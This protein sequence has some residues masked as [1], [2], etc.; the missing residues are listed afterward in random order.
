VT[1]CKMFSAQHNWC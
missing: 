1:F